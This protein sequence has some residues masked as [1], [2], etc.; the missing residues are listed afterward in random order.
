MGKTLFVYGRIYS[1]VAYTDST[2][3]AEIEG[4]PFNLSAGAKN[5]QIL[6]NVTTTESSVVPEAGCAVWYKNGKT[7]FYASGIKANNLYIIAG[8]NTFQ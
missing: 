4:N 5:L 6:T 8:A 7:E 2:K 3:I 1:S